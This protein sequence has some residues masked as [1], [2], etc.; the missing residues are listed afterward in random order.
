M[1][2]T[3]CVNWLGS[4]EDLIPLPH[5]ALI[6]EVFQNLCAW[7]N[8]G[9]INILD[10]KNLNKNERNFSGSSRPIALGILHT[11]CMPAAYRLDSTAGWKKSSYISTRKGSFHT[12]GYSKT[13]IYYITQWNMFKI[14]KDLCMANVRRFWIN[15]FLLKDGF[16]SHSAMGIFSASQNEIF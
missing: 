6:W 12:M 14:K 8:K 15:I 16:S 11:H 2:P 13:T 1:I 9:K 3:K 5:I 7:S 10:F 4:N